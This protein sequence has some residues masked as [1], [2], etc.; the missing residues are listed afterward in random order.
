MMLIRE[1]KRQQFHEIEILEDKV[2][3]LKI[4]I[5]EMNQKI[6]TLQ[7]QQDN[8]TNLITQQTEKPKGKFNQ[9]SSS[10]SAVMK[11]IRQVAKWL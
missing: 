5:K 1:K 9:T 10:F 7:H 2:G 11:V 4:T 3:Q 8:Q 6:L